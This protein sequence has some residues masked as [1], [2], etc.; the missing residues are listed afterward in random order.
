MA[1][2]ILSILDALSTN[3]PSVGRI[4]NNPFLGQEVQHLKSFW[5]GVKD[6]PGGI[7]EARGKYG[8]LCMGSS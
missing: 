4:R 8:E 3:K 6:F 1:D 2:T 7:Q 5:V